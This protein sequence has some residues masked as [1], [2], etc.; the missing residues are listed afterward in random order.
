MKRMVALLLLGLLSGCGQEP[1]A[2]TQGPEGVESPV[3]LEVVNAVLSR[4]GYGDGSGEVER[5]TVEDGKEF[6]TDYVANAYDLQDPWEDAAV[7]RGLGASA[8]ELTVVRM[9]DES[10]AVRAAAALMTYTYGRQGDFAGYAPEQADMVGRASVNQKGPYAALFICPDTNL[11]DMAFEAMLDGEP[12]PDSEDPASPVTDVKKLRDLLVSSQGMGGAELEKL[13]DGDPENLAAYAEDVYGLA[14]ELWK[15]CAVARDEGSGFEVAVF[16]IP[17]DLASILSVN[18]RLTDYLNGREAEFDADSDQGRLLHDAL[19]V[20]AATADGTA[21]ILLL[22]CENW[23]RAMAVFSEAADTTELEYTPRYPDPST[24]TEHQDRCVFIPPNKDDMSLYDTSAI[25]AAWESGDPSGLSGEDRKIYGKAKSVLRKALKDGMSDLEKET[26]IYSWIVN[27]VDYD[28]SHQ[29][30]RKETPRESFTPYGGLVK[31]KAVCLGYATTFQLLCDLAGVECIT[32][33]G[34]SF[35]SEEDHG[36]NMV[37]LDG[38]WYCVDATWDA[39]YREQGSA[40]GRPEGWDYFNVTS[41]VMAESNH[42]WDYA[43]TPEAVTEG[44][45]RG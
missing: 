5:L 36:W 28:W 30:R 26:A 43:N 14:L 20:H 17:D 24:D 3:A 15:E 38:D 16:Q 12:L 45:G 33:V 44:N 37:R 13:D 40:S 34:A 11:A 39:N 18:E 2:G 8:F 4:C 31:R 29:D 27:Q 42:Q 32:V 21:Y 25:R 10:A 35:Y 7:I 19:T 23:E 22:A 41:N 9:E 1:A 6:L